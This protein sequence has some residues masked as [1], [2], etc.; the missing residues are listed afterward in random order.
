[1]ELSNHPRVA[2]TVAL[3]RDAA[4]TFSE[5]NGRV[6]AGAVAFYTL[7]SSVPLLVIAL[8]VAALVTGE[9]AARATLLVH[10]DRWFG[11]GGV[12]TVT[13]WLGHAQAASH[14]T[15]ALGAL[16]FAYGS[17]RLFANLT[18]AFDILW[19]VPTPVETTLRQRA[20]RFLLHRL[21]AFGLVLAVGVVLVAL[22]FAHALLAA[23]RELVPLSALPLDRA[24]ELGLS[25]L[26]T[27]L[28]F[29]ALFWAL[30][31]TRVRVRDALR[32][33]LLTAALFT[34]GALGVGF[35]VAHKAAESPFGGATSL[36]V[37]MLW[38]HYAAHVFF[39]GAVLTHELAVRDQTP[40]MARD[41]P[42][43][44]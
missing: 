16:A 20:Q 23:A 2:S 40:A 38:V 13:D 32:G 44:G 5:R 15:S 17:T 36:V 26:T 31:S 25:F 6:L 12:E 28:V 42:P 19:A 10:V 4:R 39:F 30:P 7:L 43:R 24:G 34:V 33:G 11:R 29:A 9:A 22:V 27:T 3:V 1:M 14:G 35:W 37:F 41:A 21:V 8:R 18:R